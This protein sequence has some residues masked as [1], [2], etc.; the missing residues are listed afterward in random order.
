[1]KLRERE[2][3]ERLKAADAEYKALQKKLDQQVRLFFL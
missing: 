3:E 2:T 1:M